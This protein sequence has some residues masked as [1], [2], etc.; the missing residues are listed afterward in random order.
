MDEAVADRHA[1]GRAGALRRL[2]QQGG[3]AALLCCLGVDG[4]NPLEAAP[5]QYGADAVV[6]G[7]QGERD[8]DPGAGGQ[9]GT[10]W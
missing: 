10:W 6:L 4:E 9:V 1:T 8:S 7:N 2:A 3:C 5:A